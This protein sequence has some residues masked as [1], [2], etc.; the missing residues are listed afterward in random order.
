MAQ[1]FNPST[2]E[3]ETAKSLS[4]RPAWSTERV[5]GHPGYT[6]KPYFGKNKQ[7]FNF[8][9]HLNLEI[10]DNSKEAD[11]KMGG[12]LDSQTLEYLKCSLVARRK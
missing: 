2:Q 8:V 4:L 11:H 3:A 12:S 7:K 1:G 5:L 9:L 6:E 10:Q